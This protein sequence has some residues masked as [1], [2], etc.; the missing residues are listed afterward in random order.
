MVEE[1]VG[2]VFLEG[3]ARGSA[4]MKLAVRGVS[5]VY[6]ALVRILVGLW[7]QVEAWRRC[8][9]AFQRAEGAVSGAKYCAEAFEMGRCVGDS[10]HRRRRWKLER[11]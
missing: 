9:G 6:A 11:G 7:L 3:F 1:D 4:H 2:R 10:F 8:C 5:V